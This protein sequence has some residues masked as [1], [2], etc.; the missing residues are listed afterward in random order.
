VALNITEW[1][2]GV[3]LL[4]L[5]CFSYHRTM[6]STA[7]EFSWSTVEVISERVQS[8]QRSVG[9][10][11]RLLDDDNTIPFIARYR[12][13]QTNFMEPDKLREIKEELSKLR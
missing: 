13:E 10:V 8:D 1:S 3:K 7:D 12:K 6:T 5:E 11:V 4:T 2:K 9:N